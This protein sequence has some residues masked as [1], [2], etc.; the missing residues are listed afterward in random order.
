MRTVFQD[1]VDRLDEVEQQVLDYGQARLSHA[2][3]RSPLVEPLAYDPTGLESQQGAMALSRAGER[4]SSLRDLSRAFQSLQGAAP[5]EVP[6]G[7]SEFGTLGMI[8]RPSPEELGR[9]AVDAMQALARSVDGARAEG[10]SSPLPAAQ[11]AVAALASAVEVAVPQ[12]STYPTLRSVGVGGG[13]ALDATRFGEA[14]EGRPEEVSRL[15]SDPLGPG[16]AIR[17]AVGGLYVDPASGALAHG[18]LEPEV[19]A[20]EGQL[21]ESAQALDAAGAG[22][23]RRAEG[24]DQGLRSLGVARDSLAAAFAS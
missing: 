14:L 4:T 15:L 7:P 17:A 24:L 8:Q 1:V 6:V 16:G 21:A 18:G 5:E 22:L 9:R 12:N 13:G 2:V 19:R 20:L 3:S 11:Q 10:A 23:Q